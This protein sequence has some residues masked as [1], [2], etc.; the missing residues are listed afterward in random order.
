[1]TGRA[2]EPVEATEEGLFSRAYATATASFAAVM[3]LTGL[4]A[5]AVVPTLPT[6]AR[7]LDG[8][9]LYPLVAGSFVAAS[10]LGGVL[11]GH[12]A[13]RRGAHRPL[14]AGMALAV[15]TLLVSAAST[16]IWQ[17]AAGRF[18]DGVAGGMVAVSINTAIGQA[19]PERLRPRALA[20]MSACWVVP[21]L[22]GP[23]LAGLV[24]EWWSWRAVFYGLAALTVVPTLIVLSALRGPGHP[25]PSEAADD[26]P[27]PALLVALG[28][29][30]GAALG[31]YGVSAWDLRHLVFTVAGLALLVVFAPRLLPV[32]TWRAARGLPATVLLCGLGSGVFFTLEALVPLMLV[33]DRGAAPVLIGLAFTG[34]AV[35]WA[36]ASWVQ[37]HLLSR[38]PR[39]QLVVVGALVQAT[40]VVIAA[41]GTRPEVPTYAA[42]SAMPLAAI[43][44]GLYAPSLTVLSLT[45]SPPGRQGY[46]SS[47]MQTNQNLGQISVLG[48][49]AALLNACL[50][51]GSSHPAGYAAALGLLLIPTIAAAT[52]ATRARGA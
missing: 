20:L 42:A 22:V 33:T 31:Q 13:D 19:Y 40:A 7:A 34:A 48:L 17:L 50:G 2:L 30:V 49:S 35:A 26:Q 11:G 39:H 38:R 45:H 47:A 10:L 23:P 21:S 12:W 24:A 3:F 32:G 6:A 9:S 46:A 14:A 37:G 52:L 51:A 8:V 16:T 15:V 44:M 25:A 18:L 4:A 43:G 28:V 5:L 36:A 27:R 41:V 29:S 1:M